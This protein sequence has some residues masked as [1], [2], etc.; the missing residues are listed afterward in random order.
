MELENLLKEIVA[1]L[2]NLKIPY[3]FTGA[4][5][6]SFYGK[7]RTTHDF[8]VVISIKSGH[9][10]A[11]KVVQAFYKDFYVSEEGIM[12]ALIHKTMFNLIHHKTGMKIDLWILKE[13]AFSQEAFKR[14]KKGHFMGKIVY[15]LAAEDIILSKLLWYKEAESDKHLKDIEG[16]IDIQDKILDHKYL[17][18]WA[19]KLGVSDLLSLS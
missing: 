17:K 10:M 9:G 6:A 7:P 2:D 15:F 5:A 13:D 11:E 4:I 18:N 1:E 8:D 3:A 16:I 14:R 12:D 19:A